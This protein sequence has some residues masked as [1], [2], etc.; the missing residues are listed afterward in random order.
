MFFSHEGRALEVWVTPYRGV[1]RA[2]VYEN[3]KPINGIV[4]TVTRE[5]TQR[6]VPA[7]MIETL[8]LHARTD[9]EQGYVHL[10]SVKN[11]ALP[12]I[13]VPRSRGARSKGTS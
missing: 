2:K 12:T 6:T 9:V 10:P 1:W 13:G 11:K 5:K 7:H 8:M 4:Y 3:G